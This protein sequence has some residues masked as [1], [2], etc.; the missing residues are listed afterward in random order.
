MS[1]LNPGLAFHPQGEPTAAPS[2]LPPPRRI[3]TFGYPIKACW[4]SVPGVTRIN[5]LK[6]SNTGKI[7][8][9]PAS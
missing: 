5:F 8:S 9:I 3:D 1:D 7:L 4:E 2:D 6:V